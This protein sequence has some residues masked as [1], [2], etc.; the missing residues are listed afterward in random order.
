MTA[1]VIPPAGVSA[2]SFFS[3]ATFVDAAKPP[4]LL[5]DDVDTATGEWR[6]IFTFVHPVDAAV[7]EAF[8]LREGTGASV[9]TVGNRYRKIRHAGPSAKRHL[10]DETQRIM[11][12]FVARGDVAVKTL[13]VEVGEVAADTGAVFVEYSNL[14]S[15]RVESVRAA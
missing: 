14:R 9:A 11:S 4:A 1:Y 8:R 6:S 10:E 13:T 7:K 2:A 12:P 5:A 15:G 3:P